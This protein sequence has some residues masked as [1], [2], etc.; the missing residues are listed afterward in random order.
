M[1]P[2]LFPSKPARRPLF[3]TLAQTSVQQLRDAL[4]R[5]TSIHAAAAHDGDEEPF[6]AGAEDSR[7]SWTEW[8]E[9]SFDVRRF[10]G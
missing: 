8:E 4:R 5:L 3:A 2:A 10:H 6:P 9:T 7:S 1:K